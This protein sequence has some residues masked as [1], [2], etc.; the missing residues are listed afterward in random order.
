MRSRVLLDAVLVAAGS[1]ALALATA[2]L[3]GSAPLGF[4][5]V[6]AV[7]GTLALLH[8]RRTQLRSLVAARAVVAQRSASR[9]AASATVAP[10]T[11][12]RRLRR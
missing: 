2:Q 6:I 1:V 5:A 7:I 10:L 9:R 3:T 8:R 12:S 11:V 4:L